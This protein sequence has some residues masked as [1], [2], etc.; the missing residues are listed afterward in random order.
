VIADLGRADESYV[1]GNCHQVSV[2]LIFVWD[3]GSFT[4]IV[5]CIVT[6]LDVKKLE[7]SQLRVICN[8]WLTRC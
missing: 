8:G 5:T 1:A 7:A 6:W 3:M 4:C 2:N